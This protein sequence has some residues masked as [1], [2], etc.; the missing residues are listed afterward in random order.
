M[1]LPSNLEILPGV[2][3]LANGKKFKLGRYPSGKS[4]IVPYEETGA[5]A[6]RMIPTPVEAEKPKRKVIT[7]TNAKGEKVELKPF[8][9]KRLHVV[10]MRRVGKDMAIL[11]ETVPNGSNGLAA[12]IDSCLLRFDGKEWHPLFPP[13]I[14]W[15]V[16]YHIDEVQDA[17]A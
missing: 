7:V 2:Q 5:P 12:Y 8:Q 9:P 10:E 3:Q 4:V 15:H 16:Q 1:Q 13:V 14:E 6:A 17:K 11:K